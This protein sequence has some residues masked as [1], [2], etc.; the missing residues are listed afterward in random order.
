M[1]FNSKARITQYWGENPQVY[2]PYGLLGHDG[3]DAVPQG[4]DWT[5]NCIM[6]GIVTRAYTSESYGQTVL[7]YNYENKITTR[8]AH[9]SVIAVEEGWTIPEG[10]PLG[11]MGSTGHASGDHVH[12]HFILM[13]MYGVKLHPNNGYKGRVDPL[14]YLVSHNKI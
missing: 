11:T 14:S 3:V 2:I 12:I 1:L 7:I 4:T 13:G 6:G 8:Y 9:M 10:M 5:I